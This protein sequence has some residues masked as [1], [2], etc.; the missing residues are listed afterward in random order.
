MNAMNS[1]P[2]A[3]VW[4]DDERPAPE[5]WVRVYSPAAAINL[6]RTSRVSK[7][8]LDHDLGGDYE[9]GTGYDVM[10]WI[11]EQVH[12]NPEFVLPK[13]EIHT[14]NS[15]AK[16][17]MTQALDSIERKYYNNLKSINREY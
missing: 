5:G 3:R 6:L 17:R 11:E 2:T 14:A 10:L 9:I 12:T 13:I 8:S 1:N 15:A 7:I 16:R 4:L